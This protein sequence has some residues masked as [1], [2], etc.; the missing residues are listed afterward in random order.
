MDDVALLRAFEPVLRFNQGEHFLPTGVDAYVRRCTLWSLEHDGSSRRIA[1]A[2]ELDLDQLAAFGRSHGD[3]ALS[4]RFVQDE[5]DRRAA[6]AWRREWAVG[7]GGARFSA[8]GPVGRLS[9]AILRGSLLV[10]GRVPGG[11]MAAAHTA[12]RDHLDPERSPYY[13]RVLREGGWTICQY[14]FFYAANDWRT[15][16]NGVNDHEA[17]WEMVTVYVVEGDAGARARW[18][19]LSAHEYHGPRVRRRWDD[20]EV[21]FVGDHPVVYVGAGSHSGAFLRGDYVV[22]VDAPDLRGAVRAF[23]RL[24]SL[25]TPWVQQRDAIAIPFI[26]L[27]RGDGLS[28]GPG[29]NRQWQP[30][31]VGDRLPWVSDFAGLWGLETHDRLGGE[32]APSG[33]KFNRDGTLRL[34]WTD[35]L[36]WAGMVGVPTSQQEATALLAARV[37]QVDADLAAL[38]VEIDGQR[39]HVRRLGVA[40]D[41]LYAGTT[42]RDLITSRTAMLAAAEHELESSI[43]ERSRL[44]EERAVHARALAVPPPP[45]DPQLHLHGDVPRP[46]RPVGGR[47]RV[48]RV[49]SLVSVPLLLLGIVALLWQQTFG[50]LPAIGLVIFVLLSIEAF[51]RGRLLRFAGGVVLL[52]GGVLAVFWMVEYWR[53]TLSVALAALAAFILVA[54]TREALRRRGLHQGE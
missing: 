9:D 28:I 24:R 21:E 46:Y 7:G 48:L 5:F 3:R 15:S 41:S 44:L 33:P 53:I 40:V 19:A 13:A 14:W 37:E 10:R 17:D 32:R 38:A 23:S 12:Y 11:H 6:R 26:D 16:F 20:P 52:V 30:V 18:V 1:D 39:E 35:S 8:V 49:W 4:L 50:L 45:P 34:S 2:G 47:E 25:V 29:G 51:A 42:T 22:T 43:G 31:V 27:A 36:G 54:N